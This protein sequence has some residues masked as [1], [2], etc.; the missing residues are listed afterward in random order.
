MHY[1][2][3]RFNSMTFTP[4]VVTWTV[5]AVVVL[6]LALVR[7]LAGLHEDDNLHLAKGSEALVSEQVA[8]YGML[9][10]IERWGKTLTVVTVVGGLGLASVYLYQTVVIHSQILR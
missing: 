10:R 6:A 8:F 3:Q 1:S 2:W 5:L 9:A 7:N 4:F